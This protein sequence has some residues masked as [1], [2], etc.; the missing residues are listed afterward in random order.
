MLCQKDFLQ[1]Y[2]VICII[3]YYSWWLRQLKHMG[4]TKLMPKYLYKSKKI[5]AILILAKCVYNYDVDSMKTTKE[6][7]IFLKNLYNT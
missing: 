1:E 2:F 7:R 4:E 5:L 6:Q 3:D